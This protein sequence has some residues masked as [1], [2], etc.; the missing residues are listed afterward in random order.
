MYE[1]WGFHNKTTKGVN[2]VSTK[3]T[4]IEDSGPSAYLTI[5]TIQTIQTSAILCKKK[6]MLRPFVATNS[7]IWGFSED[8][9]YT[10]CV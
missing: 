7:H 5:Y 3:M 8:T 10:H 2:D 6:V 9:N 1:T 4:Q